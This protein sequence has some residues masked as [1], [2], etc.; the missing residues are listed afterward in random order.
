V[1]YGLFLTCL[2]KRQEEGSKECQSRAQR[3]QRKRR[4]KAHQKSGAIKRPT[5]KA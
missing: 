2:D 5:Q 4:G 1:A 3:L